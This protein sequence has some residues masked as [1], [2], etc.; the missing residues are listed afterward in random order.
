[1]GSLD[2]FGLDADISVSDLRREEVLDARL[3]VHHRLRLRRRNDV[4]GVLV[5]ANEW[6]HIVAYV[7]DLEERLEH[8]EE[9][10]VRNLIT[11]RASAA[12]FEQATPED[13]EGIERQYR[14]RVSNT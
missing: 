12:E 1:M 3:R 4:L 10:A 2:S 11:E 8:H 14:E 7:R 9:H 6:R 13:I 5:D